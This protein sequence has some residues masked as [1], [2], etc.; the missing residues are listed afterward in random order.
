MIKCAALAAAS[1]DQGVFFTRQ[2]RQ[3]AID[4]PNEATTYDVYGALELLCEDC[5][6]A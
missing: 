5:L 6:P 3:V 1:D 4:I 2:A